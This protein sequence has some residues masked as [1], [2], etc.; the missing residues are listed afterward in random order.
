MDACF[1]CAESCEYCTCCL[2]E[3]DVKMLTRCIQLNRECATVC[4][5]ASAFM[6]RDSEHLKQICNKCADVCEACA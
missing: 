2:R 3:Q 6:S 1:D 5:S 4:L